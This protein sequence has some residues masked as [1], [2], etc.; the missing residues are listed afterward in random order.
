MPMRKLRS[1]SRAQTDQVAA[2]AQ[3]Q[4]HLGVF[5]QGAPPFRLVLV[6]AETQRVQAP[7][8]LPERIV[9]AVAAG[10]IGLAATS[11][12][13]AAAIAR[14]VPR[15]LRSLAPRQVLAGGT[16]FRVCESALASIC[17]IAIG[18][19]RVIRPFTKLGGGNFRVISG[20]WVR[21]DTPKGLVSLFFK[22]SRT[23]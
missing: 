8:E 9:P 17:L 18:A 19:P 22:P 23:S 21:Q 2:L 14:P 13:P 4:Q 3:G 16:I 15:R 12:R 11:A 5:G 20:F 6:G 10:T 1:G 7:V